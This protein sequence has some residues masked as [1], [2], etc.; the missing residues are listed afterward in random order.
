MFD[1]IKNLRLKDYERILI[2]TFALEFAS[3]VI[4]SA[5]SEYFPVRY[6]EFN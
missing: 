1:S 2:I 4:G 5:D 6:I 3:N